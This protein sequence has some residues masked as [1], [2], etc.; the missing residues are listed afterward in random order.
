M[1]NEAC[2]NAYLNCFE[3]V[4]FADIFD[5]NDK[6]TII[7]ENLED[8]SISKIINS[9]HKVYSEEFC[10]YTLYKVGLALK[11]MHNKDLLHRDVC[12]DNVFCDRDGDIK[13]MDLGLTLP[14][15]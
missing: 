5:Y 7:F 8:G 6:I 10:R 3:I 11:A 14:V 1:K 13:L 9:Y 4:K 12:S 15:S 2:L